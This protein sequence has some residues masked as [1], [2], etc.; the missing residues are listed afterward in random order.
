MKYNIEALNLI[1]FKAFIV[2][3]TWAN[4][5]IKVENKLLN[6]AKKKDKAEDK[7]LKNKKVK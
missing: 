7:F 3:R 2:Y 1:W 5:L 4:K 6:V